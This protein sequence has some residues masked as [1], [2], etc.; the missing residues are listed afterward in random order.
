MPYDRVPLSEFSRLMLNRGSLLLMNRQVLDKGGPANAEEREC[1]RRYLDKAILA[2]ADARLAAAGRYHPT[3]V[4]KRDR[5]RHL[6]WPGSRDFLERYDR[7][8]RN[9]TGQ[10]TETIPP[11][12][13]AEAQ[14]VVVADWLEALAELESTRIGRLPAW[15]EYSSARVAKGQSASGLLGLLRNL[16]VTARE[17][18]PAEIL[19]NLSWATRYP[20][21]RLISVLPALLE[22]SLAVPRETVAFALAQPEETDRDALTRQ[23]LSFWVRYN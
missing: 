9:R 14:C 13:E 16:A 3:Y 22:P 12:H 15:A 19:Q 1:F 11:G 18:G 20:R 10:G 8:L 7:A 4:K 23:F 17:F 6:R 5:L 2:C 21:E